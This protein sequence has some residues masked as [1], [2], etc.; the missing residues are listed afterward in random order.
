MATGE[1]LDDMGILAD[2][3]LQRRRSSSSGPASSCN[4]L[5]SMYG[6]SLRARLNL[7]SRVFGFYLQWW[8]AAGEVTEL[9]FA[10]F[11]EE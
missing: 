8:R 2:E 6:I 7:R 10:A 11:N 4:S 1:R 3:K 5:S 9:D